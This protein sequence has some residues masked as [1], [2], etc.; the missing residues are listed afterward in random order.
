MKRKSVKIIVKK[1][2]RGKRKAVKVATKSF[3]FADCTQVNSLK[4]D[5]LDF[6]VYEKVRNKKAGGGVAIAAKKDLNPILI[7]EGEEDVEALTIDIHPKN[8]IISCT[9]AYGP[10]LRDTPEKKSNFWKFLDKVADSAWEEGKGFYL[11]GDLNS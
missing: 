10:Q 8:I 5:D 3:L 9:S 4:K 11:Q 2:R 1:T 7:F 6:V